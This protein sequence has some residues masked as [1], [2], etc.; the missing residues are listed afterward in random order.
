MQLLDP[1]CANILRDYMFA[2]AA[3]QRTRQKGAV[4]L[5]SYVGG[6]TGTPERGYFERSK[7]T[8]SKKLKKDITLYYHE[9][10]KEWKTYQPKKNDGWYMFFVEGDET[11]HSLAV[12]VRMERTS[13]SGAA[14]RLTDA[15]VL[16]VLAQ[17]GYIKN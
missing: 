8:Y 12:V 17:N 9:N 11:H 16:D 13:G 5:P 4:D 3:N 15:V 1:I 14:V 6:K 2:E 10:S 7:Q